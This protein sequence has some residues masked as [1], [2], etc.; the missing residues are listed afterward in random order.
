MKLPRKTS[1]SIKM[2]IEILDLLHCPHCR[3]PLA[4][5]SIEQNQTEVRRGSLRCS[6]STSHR[7]EIEDGIIHFGVGFD[8]EA[9]KKEIAYENSSYHG[10][11]NRMRDPKVVAQFP[12]TLPDLWPDTCHFGPDFRELIDHLHLRPG[13]WVL[14]VGTGPCWS[15]RL[16][17]QRGANVIAIDVNEADFYGLKT[18]DI[19]F[20]THG[21]YFERI[22]ESM[23][24]LPFKDASIDHITFNAAFHHTPDMNRTLQEC[25]RVLKP[26]GKVAMVNEE[27]VS[28][29]Q[30]L[31]PRGPVTDFGSHHDIPYAAFEQAARDA[32]FKVRYLLAHHVRQS[33]KARLRRLGD[34]VAFTME[35]FPLALKQLN[36]ALVLLDKPLPPAG[37]ATQSFSNLL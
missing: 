23:T 21:I 15:S 5:D 37:D 29:R 34:L 19:L 16:L 17:A 18:S 4:L 9:V 24:H 35:R 20:D 28:L 32:G 2:K 1:A 25:F 12:D 30:K 10:T 22:L 7:Y 33:L 13:A 3:A 11:D 31:L 36:S 27:F 8:H 26:G 6:T 14:D